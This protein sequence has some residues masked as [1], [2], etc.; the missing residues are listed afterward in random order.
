MD[1]PTDLQTLGRSFI[2]ALLA[3]LGNLGAAAVLL[4]LATELKFAAQQETLRRGTR[5]ARLD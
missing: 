2:D 5:A 1:V 3:R 4:M